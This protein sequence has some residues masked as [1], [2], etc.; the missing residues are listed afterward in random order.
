MTASVTPL[1]GRT[2]HPDE[3]TPHLRCV[4]CGSEWFELR[5]AAPDMPPAAVFS[6]DGR[7]AA[8]AVRPQCIEC[9]LTPDLP[10]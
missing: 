1:F 8:T 6:A 3:P 2:P 4:G 9:G 10:Y 5:G 7:I